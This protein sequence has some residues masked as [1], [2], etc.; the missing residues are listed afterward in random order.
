MLGPRVEGGLAGGEMPMVLASTLSPSRSDD[1]LMLS[2]D[3]LHSVFKVR[4]P[5]PPAHSQRNTMMISDQIHVS[6]RDGEMQ[7]SLN[8]NVSNL[9]HTH[10][11]RFRLAQHVWTLANILYLNQNTPMLELN[12]RKRR[13]TIKLRCFVSFSFYSCGRLHDRSTSP[14][15]SKPY[16]YKPHDAAAL[17][18]RLVYPLNSPSQANPRLAPSSNLSSTSQQNFS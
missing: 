6:R 12:E 15:S 2:L 8:D 10:P 9:T 17:P 7:V 16:I 3:L 5:P 11:H 1:A 13:S 18:R 4:C 14:R